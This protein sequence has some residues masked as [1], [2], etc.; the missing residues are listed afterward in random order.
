R[1][2][3]P[4]A[5]SRDGAALVAVARESDGTLLAIQPLRDLDPTASPDR[6]VVYRTDDVLPSGGE[7]GA[8]APPSADRALVPVGASAPRVLE[9]ALDLD[10][11]LLQKHGSSP[12]A[13]L[14]D[15]ESVLNAAELIFGAQLGLTFEV[16][17]AVVRT[18]EPDPY[19]AFLP[20]ALLSEVQA[21]W[22]GPLAAEPRDVVHLF[23]GRDLTGATIGYANIGVACFPQYAYALSETT[24][25]A[26]IL[27]RTA[28]TA[29]ELGHTLNAAHCSGAD[30]RIMCPAI[31]GCTGDAANFGLASQAAIAAFVQGNAC[32]RSTAQPHPLPFVESVP[33]PAVESSRWATAA[34]V[35]TEAPAGGAPSAPF[36]LRIEAVSGT[37]A[38]QATLESVPLALGSL[39]AA[40]CSFSVRA[41]GASGADALVVEMLTPAGAWAEVHRVKNAGTVFQ[42]VKASAPAAALHDGARMRFRTEANAAGDAFLVDDVVI[43]PPS[44]APTITSLSP[45]SVDTLAGGTVS[46]VGSGYAGAGLQVTVGGLALPPGAVTIVD[47]Q[48]L[49]FLAPSAPSLG[50]VPVQVVTAGG[51]S[52][53]AP[54]V[55]V[56]PSPPTLVAPGLTLNGWVLTLQMA[57]TPGGSAWLLANATGSAIPFGGGS[58]LDPAALLPLAPLNG[59]GLGTLSAPITGVPAGTTFSLQ[60]LT[61]DPPGNDP[62]TLEVSAVVATVVL[63]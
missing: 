55:F 30:C 12:A 25:S 20:A 23:T 32:L 42:S 43:G 37:P 38:G 14:A 39:S 59:L 22:N 50:S 21:E 6:H 51:A 36:A 47:D 62:G 27:L 9:L 5:A 44:S 1:P 2:E 53:A 34:G 4:V 58:L 18:S 35:S 45:P 17:V 48:H 49:Q 40:E 11:E 15:V 52:L 28:L 26:N 33:T 31:G 7:C 24:Y 63:F 16:N 8:A 3:T 46:V 61:V 19:D 54:L 57:G 56:P 29:H 41:A 10:R 13:A 60:L